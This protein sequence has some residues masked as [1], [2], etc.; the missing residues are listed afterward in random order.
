VMK[1]DIS[2]ASGFVCCS[3]LYRARGLSLEDI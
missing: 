1:W 2:T 3:A